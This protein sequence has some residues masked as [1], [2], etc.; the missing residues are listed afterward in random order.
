MLAVEERWNCSGCPGLGPVASHE[1]LD[2]PLCSLALTKAE[3]PLSSLN[4]P[5]P[6]RKTARKA[7]A[8]ELNYR[9]ATAQVQSK[10]IFFP[11]GA[12]ARVCNASAAFRFASQL[13]CI[14]ASTR[15]GTAATFSGTLA[16]TTGTTFVL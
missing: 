11:L 4:A 1:Q 10:V 3:G 13:G 16:A 15:D 8:P 9:N 7:L 5:F 14:P 2:V 6:H 12:D